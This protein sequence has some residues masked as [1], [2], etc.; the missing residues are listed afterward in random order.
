MGA[1]VNW[2]AS[3]S[4]VTSA[5]GPGCI[6]STPSSPQGGDLQ[7]CLSKSTAKEISIIAG[8]TGNA[9]TGF[10]L[11]PSDVLRKGGGLLSSGHFLKVDQKESAD[12]IFG[13]TADAVGTMLKILRVILPIIMC[14]GFYCCLNPILWLIDSV[15]DTLGEIPCVGGLLD[16]IAECFETL[17]EIMIC[18]ISCCAA[19]ACSLFVGA[20]AWVYYRPQIGIPLLIGSV[21]IFCGL[22]MFAV[23]RGGQPAV[24]KRKNAKQQNARQPQFAK[25]TASFATE[26]PQLGQT[27]LQQPSPYSVA[28]VPFAAPPA[29]VA[30]PAMAVAVPVQ[31]APQQMQV[32][33]PD[34]CAEGSLINVTAPDGRMMQVHV[35]AGVQ[36]G[37]PFTIQF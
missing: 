12:A 25:P 19:L 24:R 4:F 21:L 27:E 8:V 36:H 29:P 28:P 7:V 20:L 5:C 34:G 31:P 2:D 35:P 16:G 33:C 18:C 26:Q 32:V 37:Q 22:G 11:G 9:N 30:A 17:A 13:E 1:K 10:N 15:G 3:S 14:L 6:C 23:S